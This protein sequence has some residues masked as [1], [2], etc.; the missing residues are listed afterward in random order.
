MARGGQDCDLAI[1]EIDNGTSQTNIRQTFNHIEG[2]K[3]IIYAIGRV[4]HDLRTKGSTVLG[5]QKVAGQG[6][7][8]VLLYDTEELA[9]AEKVVKNATQCLKKMPEIYGGSEIQQ[10]SFDEGKKGHCVY[11]VVHRH[12]T[13]EENIA[14]KADK[15]IRK[16]SQTLSQNESPSFYIGIASGQDARHAMKRRREGDKYKECHGINR[17]IAIYKSKD[18]KECREIEKKLIDKF[19]SYPKNLNRIGGGGGRRTAQD[20][21]YVYIGMHI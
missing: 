12:V 10:G 14:D 19:Q 15:L 9:E 13:Y 20:W 8:L 11:A 7:W 4:S 17:M 2:D 21:S 6:N 1:T 5:K 18:Q 16:V 3:G